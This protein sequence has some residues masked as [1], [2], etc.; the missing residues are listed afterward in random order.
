M[1]TAGMAATRPKAVASKASA[2]PGATTARLVVCVFRNADE[3][4]HDAPDGAE[5]ADE[6]GRRAD[7]AENAGAAID[8]PAS[9]GLNP[10]DQRRGALLDAVGVEI[11]GAID[12]GRAGIDHAHHGAFRAFELGAG[13][14]ER[15]C[16]GEYAELALRLLLGGKEFD[17]LAI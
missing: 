17:A 6:R 8:R 7:R 16:M 3:A 14:V 11:G 10:R 9:A 2:M 5:K 1:I 13:R 15:R 12:F 4:V